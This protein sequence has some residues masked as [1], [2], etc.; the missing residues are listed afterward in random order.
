MRLLATNSFFR[1]LPFPVSGQVRQKAGVAQHGDE[2]ALGR[3]HS[4]LPVLKVNKREG[5]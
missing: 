3:S 5:E 2:E 4:G 1:L